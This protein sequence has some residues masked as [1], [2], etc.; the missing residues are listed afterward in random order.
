MVKNRAPKLAARAFASQE[1]T[2]YTSALAKHPS[3][4]PPLH[5]VLALDTYGRRVSWPGRSGTQYSLA[6]QGT[7][8]SG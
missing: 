2:R 5:L 7:S 3:A 8:G 1:G 4:Q 6:I